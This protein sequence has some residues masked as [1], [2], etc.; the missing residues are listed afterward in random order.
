MLTVLNQHQHQRHP[1]AI[2]PAIATHDFSGVFLRDRGGAFKC[3]SG[4]V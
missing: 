3:L 4:I 1:S 2:A